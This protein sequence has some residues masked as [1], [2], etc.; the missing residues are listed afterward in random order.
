MRKS[1]FISEVKKRIENK[2]LNVVKRA[3]LDFAHHIPRDAQEEALTALEKEPKSIGKDMDLLTAVKQ[4]CRD[5]ESGEY[6][7]SWSFEDGYYDG[8]Y[9]DDET[10][11]DENGLGA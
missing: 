1:D 5:V 3:L 8:G 9:Y 7:L 10:L 4:L 6:P 2:T 11:Y